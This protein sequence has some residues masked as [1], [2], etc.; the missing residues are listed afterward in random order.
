MSTER[1]AGG[2]GSCAR[3]NREDDDKMKLRDLLMDVE[4][5]CLQGSLDEEI[6]SLVYDSR[7]VEPGCAFVCLRG[8]SFDGHDFAANAVTKGAV[9][10]IVE[11]DVRPALAKAQEE[12]GF[13]SEKPDAGS[14]TKPA[15]IK[16]ANTR[17]ALAISAR[18]YFGN[19]AAKLKIIGLTGTKGK[20]TTT[21]MIKKILEEA[22]H[23]V[24]MIGTLGA[25]IGTEKYKTAN[26]TPESY[27]LQ[28]LFAKMLEEGCEY[29]VMEVSSQALK[30][31]RTDGIEFSY[32]AFLNISPDHISPTEHKDFQEYLD[33]K[34]LLFRQTGPVIV[35]KDDPRWQEATELAKDRIVT[36]SQK[37]EADYMA[38]D[39]HNIW[40]GSFLG[41][42]FTLSGKRNAQVS[43]PMP[44]TFNVENALI[45]I[46]ITAEI[47]ISTEDIL[48]G[49]AKVYVKGRTQ[50]MTCMAGHGTML[51][52]YAHNAVSAENLL[53][54]LKAYKPDR[55]IC[56]F[57]GG[58][59]R[60]K[61]RRYDMGEA[62]GKYADLTVLTMDNPR[63]EEVEEIN[64]TII[65]G[66]N[67]H[68]GKYITIIDREEAIHYLIDNARP[69]D[70]IALLGKGHEEY[71]EIKGQK[72]Y[73]SEEKIIEEYCQKKFGN[74]NV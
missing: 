28:R 41:V 53:S 55:L 63:D 48:N 15:V 39:V 40:E 58:G 45:A 69:G 21:H 10:L 72:Y 18:N 35:N 26:T 37:G 59:N 38:S 71:Q 25:F 46:A 57:G 62:S 61:A 49:L 6:G 30:L 42:T 12:S 22:G 7:K 47:G 73:F 32:G 34:K 17:K 5:E 60:A 50:L 33:C 67:V 51:I 16:V 20:T 44:G 68:S 64:K 19:P 23:K 2:T 56:L 4:Y 9:A 29:A 74:G 11:E 24:G 27:E 66:L 14:E 3:E 8:A 43:I 1:G 70:I 13:G 54:M 65:E 31:G 36:V 52:D